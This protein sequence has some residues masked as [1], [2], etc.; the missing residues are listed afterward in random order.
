[1]KKLRFTYTNWKGEKHVYVV[2][3][4]S[5]QWTT[6]MVKV[7][8]E[9]S[10]FHWVINAK[11]LTRDGEVRKVRRTFILSQMKDVEEVDG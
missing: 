6:V 5:F 9:A 10:E 2:E 7:A 8:V 1:M 11:C 4:Y 3:P